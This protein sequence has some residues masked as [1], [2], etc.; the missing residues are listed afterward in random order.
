[1]AS[2]ST[3]SSRSCGPAIPTAVRHLFNV[4]NHPDEFNGVSTISSRPMAPREALDDMNGPRSVIGRRERSGRQEPPGDVN[5]YSEVIPQGEFIVNAIQ[6]AMAQATP[7]TDDTVAGTE[8]YMD[9]LADNDDLLL[10]ID[11]WDRSA[12]PASTTSRSARSRRTRTRRRTS[13]TPTAMSAPTCPRFGVGDVLYSTNPGEA[14]PEVN[15]A[16]SDSVSGARST[17][18]VGMAGDMLG[19]YYQRADYTDQEFRALSRSTT[20]GPTWRRTMPTSAPRTPPP[21]A[22]PPLRPPPP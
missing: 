15:W 6:L 17:N 5:D 11:L 21:S 9:T 22:S 2:R 1:M 14:F 12:A 16:I 4:P 3:T 19:Y 8:S 10:G 7:L 18:V 13:T 20:S